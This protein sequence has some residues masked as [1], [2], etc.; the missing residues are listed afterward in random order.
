MVML[1]KSPRSLPDEPV[2]DQQA[3]FRQ[4][5]V[6]EA[7]VRLFAR[8]LADHEMAEHAVCPLHAGVGVPE[9]GARSGSQKPWGIR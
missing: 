2:M 6:V 5:L 3:V 7:G 8:R 9:L 4:I 1:C